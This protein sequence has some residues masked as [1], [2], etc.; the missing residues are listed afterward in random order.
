MTEPRKP[1]PAAPGRPKRQPKVQG[2]LTAQNLERHQN[3]FKELRQFGC[4]PCARAWWKTVSA[5]KF[6]SR[7]RKCGVRYD[8][9]P[10]DQQHGHGVFECACGHRWTNSK[11]KGDLEQDCKR[12]GA[13]VRVTSIGPPPKQPG[14][15][16]SANRHS[17]A[18]CATGACRFRFVPSQP[19]HTTGSTVSTTAS[20]I[21]LASVQADGSIDL[22]NAAFKRLGFVDEAN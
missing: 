22:I 14:Q 20:V 11:A 10:V 16:R 8:A 7:C 4:E 17:C 21:T 18:G 13:M 9:V 2:K 5:P 1:Q 6:V 15:R 12:C 3:Q 19:H